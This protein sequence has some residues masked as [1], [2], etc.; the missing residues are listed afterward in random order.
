ME[1]EVP[2][3]SSPAQEAEFWKG[4]ANHWKKAAKDAKEEL[5]EFQ[6]MSL[7]NRIPRVYRF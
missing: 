7:V 3:F 4:R 5:D 2:E 1:E 6:V